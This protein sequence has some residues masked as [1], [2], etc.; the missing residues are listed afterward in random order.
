MDNDALKRLEKNLTR[1]A[2]KAK[3]Y[4]IRGMI[5]LT[6]SDQGFFPLESIPIYN[7]LTNSNTTMAEFIE[8]VGTLNQEHKNLNQSFISLKMSLIL[9]KRILF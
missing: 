8:S 3:K 7:T 5:G 2:T 4:W 9:S 1:S 6:E